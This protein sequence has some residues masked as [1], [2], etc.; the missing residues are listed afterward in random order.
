MPSACT[1]S[2]RSPNSSQACSAASGGARNI[3]AAALAAWPRRT[4]LTSSQVPAPDRPIAAHAS[5]AHSAT[6]P[7]QCSGASAAWIATIAAATSMAPRFCQAELARK[8]QAAMAGFCKR[9]PMVMETMASTP[10][11]TIQGDRA[12]AAG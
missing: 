1:A 11:S 4:R 10:S 12:D 8:S 7:C 3:S 9:V 6:P 5:P 2:S